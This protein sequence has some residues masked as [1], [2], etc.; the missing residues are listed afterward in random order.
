MRV[1]KVLV[2]FTVCTIGFTLAHAQHVYELACPAGFSPLPAGGESYNQTTG[3]WRANICIA[4]DGSGRQVCQM[5]NC[6]GG[7]GGGGDLSG[8]TPPHLLKSATPTTAVDSSV[9][10]NG[11]LVSTTEPVSADSFRSTGTANAD[12]FTEVATP[13]TS[14]CG[15]AALPDCLWMDSTNFRL[16]D[17]NAAGS[18]GTTIVALT[19][20][21][22]NFISAI[23]AAGVVT[24][25]PSGAGAG[26][27]GG[28]TLN[29]V[30]KWTGASSLGNSQIFDDGTNPAKSPDGFNVGT[31]AG[32]DFDI[33]ND[34]VTGTT[35][36][37]AACDN[38]AGKAI[39]CPHA[40]STT[41][42][43]LG[44]VVSGAGT[45]GNATV[46]DMGWCLVKFDNSTTARHYAIGST[47]VDGEL[48]DNGTALV[49]G[50]P[51]YF[52]V[53]AN[54]G[55]GNAAYVR[56]LTADDWLNST[57]QVYKLQ[58]NAGALT[59]GD[60]V[61]FGNTPA[62]QANSINVTFQ[63]SKSGT[64]DSVS[65]EIVGDGNSAHALLG[66]GTFGAVPLAT[67]YT[68]LRCTNIGL[69]D[70]LNAIASGTYTVF[71][72][73]NDSGVTWTI[74][75][76]HCWTDNAGTSTLQAANNAG[77]NLLTGAVTCNSTKS[78]GGA[79]GTQSG[80]TTLAANDAVTFTF[81]SDGSTK[82][83]T[84]TVSLTQ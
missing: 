26:F 11:S 21:A 38:G 46:C 77:T 64:T 61:N 24:C 56:L 19:C 82:T 80:T 74:T 78:A 22:G 2:L 6:P 29:L 42:Q 79:A 34:T 28:G 69:G 1:L 81:V 53:T 49:A 76:I 66:N 17:R 31:T 8:L 57:V 39:V 40:S 70:G 52:V 73:V 55:A 43:P 12:T 58:V 37:T 54:G 47:T 72:C 71:G 62:A 20:G 10:D 13:S 44:F 30:T 14:L 48:H 23:S 36:Q 15:A 5:D 65:A 32:Y 16:H 9:Q 50:Q 33:A 4:D 68:K 63:T 84:W 51:N 59:A 41:N 7:G 25:S 83:T 67:Q 27:T 18:I 60:T 75:G 35:A 45:A 3:Q